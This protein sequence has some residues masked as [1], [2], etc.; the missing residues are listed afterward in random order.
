MACAGE[1]V[2]PRARR[3]WGERRG[4]ENS[5]EGWRCTKQRRREGERVFC[6]GVASPRSG[7]QRASSRHRQRMGCRI[8]FSPTRRRDRQPTEPLSSILAR[9]LDVLSFSFIIRY[10]IDHTPGGKSLGEIYCRLS[11]ARGLSLDLVLS[12]ERVRPA[13]NNFLSQQHPP[14]TLRP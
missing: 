1:T 7:S 14:S 3:G 4:E 12:A 8:D 5:Q 11:E 9:L 10:F 13:S 6:Y 2:G